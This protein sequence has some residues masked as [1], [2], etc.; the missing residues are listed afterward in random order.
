MEGLDKL[1]PETQTVLTVLGFLVA[2]IIYF[3]GRWRSLTPP[4]AGSA[5][6]H[7]AVVDPKAVI[8]MRDAIEDLRED[9]KDHDR[10]R[11][12]ALSEIASRIERACILLDLIAQDLRA[13]RR[14]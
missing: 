7:I 1:S 10:R 12:T 3:V 5:T 4:S 9:L 13:A 14:Y 8:E 11:H 2:T 6:P